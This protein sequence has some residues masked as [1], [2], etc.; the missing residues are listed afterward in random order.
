ME[1]PPKGAGNGRMRPSDKGARIPTG[2]WHRIFDAV[3][4]LVRGADHDASRATYLTHLIE[5]RNVPTTRKHRFNLGS[6]GAYT[7]QNLGDGSV[8]I[9]SDKG[10]YELKYDAKTKKPLHF[11]KLKSRATGVVLHIDV[12]SINRMVGV[13][14]STVTREPIHGKAQRL[15]KLNVRTIN[16]KV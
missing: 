14:L 13:E 2:M 7:I 11:S 3:H 10:R 16:Q 9:E 12:G 5:R 6:V 4:G 1:Q 15:K 8:S